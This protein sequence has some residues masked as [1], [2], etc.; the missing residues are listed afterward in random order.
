MDSDEW[1]EFDLDKPEPK[2]YITFHI[3]KS[4]D[5]IQHIFTKITFSKKS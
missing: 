3:L 4:F 5:K 2:R 1:C